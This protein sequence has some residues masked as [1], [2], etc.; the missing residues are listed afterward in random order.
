V[1]VLASRTDFFYEQ[2]S[3]NHFG[4]I[5]NEGIWS[6]FFSQAMAARKL[7]LVR[8]LRRAWG[9]WLRFSGTAAALE[10]LGLD[11]QSKYRRMQEHARTEQGEAWVFLFFFLSFRSSIFYFRVFSVGWFTINLID[12]LVRTAALRAL[13]ADQLAQE[14][15]DHANQVAAMEAQIRK[16]N[17]DF[18]RAQSKLQVRWRIWNSFEEREK[19]KGPTI[20]EMKAKTDT[21]GDGLSAII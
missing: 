6:L 14:K 1:K 20:P 19:K 11:W 18:A 7:V 9:G 17:A 3:L 10:S 12:R 4:F 21:T 16:L 13:H 5:C 2:G 15:E 8:R